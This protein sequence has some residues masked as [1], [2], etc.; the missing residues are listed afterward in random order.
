MR[1]MKKLVSVLC[2]GLL[3]I[4]CTACG[5]SANTG[6][7]SVL[8]EAKDSENQ[9]P[10]PE[11][12]VTFDMFVD[13]T[14]LPY[15]T[16]E[17]GI[18]EQLI[19]EETG[20]KIN[21]VKATDAE[22][23]NLLIASDDLPDLVM[24]SSSSKFNKLSGDDRCWP[25]QEL[26]DKYTPDFKV[27]E[28]EQKLNALSSEDGKYYM[29]KNEF[30]TIEE[31]QNAKNI[32]PN[33]GQLIMREDIYKELGSPALQTKDDFFALMQMVKDKYPD[34]VPLTIN[35]R[36]YGGLAQLVGYDP[37][38]PVDENGN[39]VCDIS[40][41]KYRE[42]CKVINDLYRKGYV[43]EENFTFTSDEQTFQNIGTG[44]AF[45]VTHFAG[46]DEQNFTA[47]VKE[48]V[49]GA[50]YVQVPIMKDWS[51]TMPVAGWSAMFITKNCKDPE[52]AIKFLHWAKQK[53]NSIS[54]STGYKGIDWDYDETGNIILLERRQKS[55]DAGTKDA[56]YK[57]DGFIFSADDYITISNG[58]YA[59]ATPETRKIYDEAVKRAN[60][61]NALDLAYPKSGTDIRIKFDDISTLS[62][63][64]FTKI[65]TAKSD[66]EFNALYDDMVK[67]AEKIGLLEVNEYLTTNY[68]KLCEDL[69]VK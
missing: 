43:T 65:C 6:S 51:Y 49:P 64:S 33:F 26:I 25:L 35:M 23:L 52:T 59:V 21:I 3:A 22:Q 17:D 4:S 32:G 48:E 36:Q 46:N 63:E 11:N 7:D 61:S 42:L 28:I 8:M 27:P 50:K 67:E 47:R 41:P 1:K 5:K 38:K 44:K 19:E 9:F 66:E 29:L 68:N 37:V 69:G 14:W 55:V 13:C 2:V 15:D 54:L 24:T 10:N 39:Y 56:D 30:N 16:M 31:I 53:D 57:G 20:I 62:S 45:M 34:M 58:F 18:I 12:K 60:W 40:D